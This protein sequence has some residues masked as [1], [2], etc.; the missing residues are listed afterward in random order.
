MSQVQAGDA[1]VA[2]IVIN[3]PAE[4]VFAALS[5]P[6][7]RVQWWGA[8]EKFQATQMDSDLRPGGAWS[9]SGTGMGGNPFT[10][11]GVYRAIERPQLLEFTWQPDWGEPETLVRFELTESDGATNVRLTHSGF[12]DPEAHKRYQGWPWLLALLKSHSEKP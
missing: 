5:D 10:I 8:K 4:R 2:E 3:A 6:S 9:M 11:R 12:A 7:Q 1:I